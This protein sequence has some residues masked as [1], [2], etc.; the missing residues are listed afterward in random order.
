MNREK[1]R[2][3]T[4]KIGNNVGFS[5]FKR[6]A[7]PYKE[8]ETHLLQEGWMKTGSVGERIHYF[9]SSGINITVIDGMN[10]TL[11]MPSGPVRGRL[12]SDSAGGLMS[13]STLGMG[14]K[15][16]SSNQSKSRN[17]SSSADSSILV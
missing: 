13:M 6:E 2:D 10:A 1:L 14:S 16:D 4:M 8:V 3:R 12:F 15:S 11:V 7:R 5:V 9:E 17:R